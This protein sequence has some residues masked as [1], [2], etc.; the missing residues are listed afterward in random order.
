MKKEAE[1]KAQKEADAQAKRELAKEIARKAADEQ[2]K[3]TAKEQAKKQEPKATAASSKA[4]SSTA[5]QVTSSGAKTSTKA[6]KKGKG[7]NNRKVVRSSSLLDE[8]LPLPSPSPAVIAT[9]SLRE[10]RLLSGVVAVVA[11]LLSMAAL[12]LVYMNALYLVLKQLGNENTYMNETLKGAAA[13]LVMV[14]LAVIAVAVLWYVRLAMDPAK[15]EAGNG[16]G[17]KE[18]AREN[19]EARS[20]KGAKKGHTQKGGRGGRAGAA[21]AVREKS[22]FAWA[23]DKVFSMDY[24]QWTLLGAM[25]VL[26]MAM[27]YL[28]HMQ[29][30]RATRTRR[31]RGIVNNGPGA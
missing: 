31:W 22:M 16:E 1:E 20:Q 25:A 29:N 21:A 2:A 15:R 18:H 14:G 8:P 27:F 7:S 3:K 26:I 24:E 17:G 28:L 5:Q 12:Y 6:G 23:T 30:K 10:A 9:E 19:E 13:P 4:A 11:V